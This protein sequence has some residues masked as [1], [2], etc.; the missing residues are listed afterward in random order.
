MQTEITLHADCI[1]FVEQNYKKSHACLRSG[2]DPKNEITVQ[3]ST[4][5]NS[6]LHVC[7]P[8]NGRAGRDDV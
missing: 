8:V 6:T 2:E 1:E 5:G 4:H 3:A 7:E